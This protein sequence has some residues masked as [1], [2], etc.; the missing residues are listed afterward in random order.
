MLPFLSPLPEPPGPILKLCR[1]IA[2]L[3]GWGFMSLGNED[4]AKINHYQAV[5]PGNKP[6][7]HW[8]L[9]MSPAG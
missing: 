5:S 9:V 8:L 4:P 1:H 2:P 3:S 6:A 7:S